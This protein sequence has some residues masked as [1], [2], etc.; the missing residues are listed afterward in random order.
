MRGSTGPGERAWPLLSLESVLPEFPPLG[1][2]LVL[3]VFLPH[4]QPAL[5][6]ALVCLPSAGE[7][8]T[9]LPTPQLHVWKELFDELAYLWGIGSAW[10]RPRQR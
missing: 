6:K 8:R 4:S 3:G 1:G 7:G 10:R 2:A 5:T 9:G